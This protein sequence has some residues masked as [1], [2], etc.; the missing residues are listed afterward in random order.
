M[1]YKK[2]LKY[3]S[4]GIE[5]LGEIPE[6]WEVRRLKFILN[7]RKILNK[8]K[9]IKKILSLSMYEGVIPYD[10]RELKGGNKAKE[11]IS[12][13]KIVY[14]GD[15]VV[16]SMNI[17]A[18]SVG[19][20]KY[21]GIVSPVYYMLYPISNNVF[22][23]FYYYMFRSS[24][25]QKSLFGL[26]NGILFKESS[27][28]K[29]NTIRLRISMESLGN[30]ILPLPPLSEQKAIALFLD[31]ATEKIDNLIQKE[32]EL[33]KL[34]EEK[35]EALITKAVT[36]GL[37]EKAK[38]KDSGIEWL[39]KIPEH[40]K[41]R[42]LKYLINGKLQYGAN[43]SGQTYNPNL[44]RYIRITDFDQNGK[45]ANKNKLSLSW[46]KAK[47]YLLKKGDVLFARSG[48]T[49]GKTFQFNPEKL[50]DKYYAFAGYLIKAEPN[51]KII[52]SDFLYFF[53]TS[54]AY[55]NWK[56][57]I[58]SKSTIENIG[59]DKYSE[60]ILPLPPLQEQ[61]AIAKYLDKKL[62]KIDKLIEKSKKTIELLKEKKEA[63]I[64]NAVTGKIDVRENYEA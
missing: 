46:E 36:K 33:I 12:L 57:Y 56:D 53:T 25:F 48:A 58:F 44:P 21:Q 24:S 34:L 13:Y 43:E 35:K 2:Y 47:N 7:E 64:T 51:K 23:I 5:W 37:N 6:H 30:V 8:N 32:E 52:T 17:I 42:K 62:A 38:M 63:L 55:K 26:G 59:A 11:D 4:S 15:I 45:L 41:V 9:K 16:N 28:G 40:W 39:G 3:K 22:N 54:K 27:S 1:K 10:E 61:K 49:V 14:P 20:S 50:E 18:G 19:I 60:L 31:K 29:L